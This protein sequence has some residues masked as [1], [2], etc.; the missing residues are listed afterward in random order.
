M[1]HAEQVIDVELRTPICPTMAPGK[2]RHR[3]HP[4]N[5]SSSDLLLPLTGT[6]TARG[7]LLLSACSLFLSSPVAIVGPLGDQLHVRAIFLS[8]ILGARQGTERTIER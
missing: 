3:G 2:E 6:R 4:D 7:L 1:K 8:G 5:S